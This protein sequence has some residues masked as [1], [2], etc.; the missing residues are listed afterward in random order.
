MEK[1]ESWNR[2]VVGK[3]EKENDTNSSFSHSVRVCLVPPYIKKKKNMHSPYVR[4]YK[5]RKKKNFFF[6]NFQNVSCCSIRAAKYLSKL[7]IASNFK[8]NQGAIRRVKVLL[9]KSSNSSHPIC[10]GFFSLAELRENDTDIKTQA[11]AHYRV[12]TNPVP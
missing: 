4:Q 9:F 1:D 8:N 7:A 2:E 3:R 10:E 11:K 12:A 5:E 6:C